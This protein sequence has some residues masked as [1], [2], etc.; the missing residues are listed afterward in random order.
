LVHTSVV[1]PGGIIIPG[2]LFLYSEGYFTSTS[3]DAT[4][5]YWLKANAPGTITVTCGTLVAEGNDNLL[6]PKGIL[7][8]FGKIDISDVINT[9]ETLYFNG[10][11]D[12]TVSIESYSMPP[13]PPVGSF[14]VRLTNDYRLSESDEVTIQVQSSNYPVSV[15]ITDISYEEGY[16]Y[17]LQEIAGGVEAGSHR[18]VEGVEIV[19]GNEKVSLLKITKQEAVPSSYALEQNYPNPFNPSTTIKFAVPKESN[20]NLSIYNVLGEIVSTLVDEEMIPGYYEY[21]FDALHYASGVYLYSITAGDF[22][23]TK[24]MV[25]LR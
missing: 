7:A 6:L 8:D 12:E 21:E 22:V 15:T 20:V 18:I 11:L 3:I 9:G 10:K 2:S 13:V 16:G 14:D 25:L 24:K 5:G 1:D 17:L 4:E 23:E 19:I